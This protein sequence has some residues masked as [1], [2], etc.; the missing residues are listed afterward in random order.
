[1]A[2]RTCPLLGPCPPSWLLLLVPLDSSFPAPSSATVL[3]LPATPSPELPVHPPLESFF[4]QGDSR[5]AF[6]RGQHQPHGALADLP[7]GQEQKPHSVGSGEKGDGSCASCQT[8][9]SATSRTHSGSGWK[10]LLWVK[11][12]RTLACVAN[13]LQQ[14]HL[15]AAEKELWKRFPGGSHGKSGD[16]GLI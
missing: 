5:K 11:S 2:L 6:K 7:G 9:P 12:L 16:W 15:S 8:Q 3:P 10:F 4:T 1:M 13:H 14:H